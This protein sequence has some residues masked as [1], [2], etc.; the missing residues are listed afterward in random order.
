MPSYLITGVARGIG[1]EFVRQYSA[2]PQNTVIGIVRNKAATDAKIAADA[3]LTSRTNIHILEADITSYPALQAAAAAT[4]EITGGAL[5]VLIGNAGIVPLFDNFDS[6]RTLAADP[7]GITKWMRELNEVNV[8][9]NIHLFNLFTPLLLKGTLKKALVISTGLADPELTNNFDISNAPL[10]SASKAAVNMVVSKF[11][12]EY[13]QDGLL[14]FSMSPGMVDVGLFDNITEEQ[15][16]K[17]GGMVAK[18]M[19]YAPHFTGPLTP[20]QS[21]TLM[22]GVIERAS[23]EGGMGGAFVSQ[24]GNGVWL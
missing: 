5:D 22:R 10:Y 13:K 18:F 20:E 11:N 19:K 7:E 15:K 9:G 1:Y 12:A 24:H 16:S 3:D 8:L 17:V 4:A 2:D 21:V 14:F 6:F 23:I